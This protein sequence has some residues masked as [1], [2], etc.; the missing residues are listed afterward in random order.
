MFNNLSTHIRVARSTAENNSPHEIR[1]SE[2]DTPTE[3]GNR[4]QDRV[5]EGR[6]L[7]QDEDDVTQIKGLQYNALNEGNTGS[8]TVLEQHEMTTIRNT[9]MTD[10]GSDTNVQ[11]NGTNNGQNNTAI[12]QKNQTT[13]WNKN[14][15][16]S[17]ERHKEVN[18][19]EMLERSNRFVQSSSST[20]TRDERSFFGLEYPVAIILLIVLLTVSYLI[21]YGLY[22]CS[23][24][25]DDE[26][27]RGP[28]IV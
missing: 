21:V 1:V 11:Q 17:T 20:A 27:K 12:E 10:N 3:T 5:R 26:M 23:S 28:M 14:G 25:E 24:Y 15:Y 4:S 19:T 2:N 16:R 6:M 8:E 9:R 18:R 22:K 7:S 13:S